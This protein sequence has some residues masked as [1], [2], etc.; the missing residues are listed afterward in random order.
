MINPREKFFL[1]QWNILFGFKEENKVS[2]IKNF[3]K[4]PKNIFI[5]L[6]LLV[7]NL[8]TKLFLTFFILFFI[9]YC[10][11]DSNKVR[12]EDKRNLLLA[13]AA[14]ANECGKEGPSFLVFPI[15]KNVNKISVQICTLAILQMECPFT[16]YP[17]I[18]IEMYN[19]DYPDAGPK[20]KSKI[21]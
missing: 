9:A 3:V 7:I 10:V 18:C 13:I 11:D 20:I 16:G 8:L 5:F 17:L 14:K 15:E 4:N 2:E 21:K 6:R 19:V 1:C 12:E